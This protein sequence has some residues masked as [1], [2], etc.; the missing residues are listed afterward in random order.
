MIAKLTDKNQLTI[1][2]PVVFDLPQSE[3]YDVTCEDGRIVLTPVSESV[4][5][6]RADEAIEMLRSKGITEQ[7]VA[8]AIAWARGK[9]Q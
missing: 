4:I 9:S 8:D 7:D 1:P 2:D 3:F 6:K 5:I